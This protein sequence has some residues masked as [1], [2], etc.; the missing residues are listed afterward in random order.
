MVYCIEPKGEFRK[1]LM[2]TLESCGYTSEAIPSGK[3][4][5]EVL[6]QQ[7][8]E[9]FLLDYDLPGEK[10]LDILDVLRDS[11]EY[12]QIPVIM[13]SDTNEGSRK[14]QCFDHGAD[15]YLS[16]TMGRVEMLARIR[17]VL[18]RAERY[19]YRDECVRIQ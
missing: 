2:Y 13:V 10:G 5:L 7:R 14:V 4:L 18:R 15:D 3:E 12:V 16:G 8:P 6:K 9:L 11:F 1:I 17:A 19:K